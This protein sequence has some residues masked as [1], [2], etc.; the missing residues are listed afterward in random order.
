MVFTVT[1]K[2]RFKV[3][4]LP[5]VFFQTK[6]IV[7]L[8]V[9]QKFVCTSSQNHTQTNFI[10]WKKP[11]VNT[12]SNFYKTLLHQLEWPSF[13]LHDARVYKATKLRGEVKWQRTF[14]SFLG[15][16]IRIFFVLVV[17]FSYVFK[18]MFFQVKAVFPI[19]FKL[20]THFWLS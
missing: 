4:N 12:P 6:I 9:C 14:K 19:F 3:P 8:Y 5:S 17:V 13:L 11:K 2:K 10:G 16:I 18:K 20:A 7:C 1:R 15:A